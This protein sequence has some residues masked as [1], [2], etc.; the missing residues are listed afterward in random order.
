MTPHVFAQ[1]IFVLG[2]GLHSSPNPIAA[3]PDSQGDLCTKAGQ[4]CVNHEETGSSCMVQ[5]TTESR[6]GRNLAGPF[7]TRAEAT[8][9]MCKQ[10]YD[11]ASDDPHKCLAVVPDGV[12]DNVK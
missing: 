8:K 10:Y 5:E 7:E 1:L 12:C 2:I 6:I 3:A 4:Y 11:P 9:V